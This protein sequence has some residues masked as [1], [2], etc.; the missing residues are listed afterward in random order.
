MLVGSQDFPSIDSMWMD[1][2]IHYPDRDDMPLPVMISDH[3]VEDD[4]SDDELQAYLRVGDPLV[5]EEPIVEEVHTALGRGLRAMAYSQ[6]EEQCKVV[7]NATLAYVWRVETEDDLSITRLW[8]MDDPTRSSR[9]LTT[10]T[11]WQ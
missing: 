1:K 5:I 2:W 6:F 8:A 10:S 11:T 4:G 9:P 3:D 7:I